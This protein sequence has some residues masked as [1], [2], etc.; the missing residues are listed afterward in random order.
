MPSRTDGLRASCT[1]PRVGQTVRCIRNTRHLSTGVPDP[2]VFVRQIETEE[3]EEVCSYVTTEI[4]S[5]ITRKNGYTCLEDEHTGSDGEE[6]VSES[7]DEL[8]QA[9]T[10]VDSASDEE[11]SDLEDDHL[12]EN[13]KLTIFVYTLDAICA[14]L[15]DYWTQAADGEMSIIL[16]AFL[17][18]TAISGIQRTVQGMYRIVP[19]H[20]IFLKKWFYFRVLKKTKLRFPDMAACF[21]SDCD[22][23]AEKDGVY[24]YWYT[25]RDLR[26][27][28]ENRTAPSDAGKPRSPMGVIM[29]PAEEEDLLASNSNAMDGKDT[30]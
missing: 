28:F 10:P 14:Q 9:S 17:P 11:D 5:S 1:P 8:I 12:G 21:D 25:L 20:E 18:T 19:D 23:F 13:I 22:L 7:L 15:K 29:N 16:A 26:E 27:S 24:N 2:F 3:I 6:D 4:A 30:G